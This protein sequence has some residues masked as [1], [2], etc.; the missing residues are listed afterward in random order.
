MSCRESE[1]D[2]ELEALEAEEPEESEHDSIAGKRKQRSLVFHL[3]YAME[4]FDYDI[5]LAALID[6]FNRGFDLAIEPD[7]Q[8]A[9][10]VKAIIESRHEL[11]EYIQPLLANWRLERVGLC[12]KL[13]LRMAVWE[14]YNTDIAPKIIINE[15]IELAKCFSEREAY[16][17]INGV[18]DELLKR[19]EKEKN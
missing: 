14:L 4:E 19:I 6:N 8:L 7:G 5:S 3:I 16:K 9:A 13:I 15:A 10:L 1:S 2:Q 17:F 18:L 11:D 12:T